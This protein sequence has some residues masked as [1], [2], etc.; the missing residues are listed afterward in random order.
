[1]KKTV[2]FVLAALF[3]VV[4]TASSVASDNN[5]SEGRVSFVSSQ[6]PALNCSMTLN[7]AK[8]IYWLVPINICELCAKEYAAIRNKYNT[9]SHF[10]H[11]G[12]DVRITEKEGR[13]NVELSYLG[14]KVIASDVTWADLDVIFFGPENS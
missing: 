10:K 4:L 13:V 2:L 1:M 3:A 9:S 6:M 14:N 5:Q 7:R 12:V 8:D 11:E